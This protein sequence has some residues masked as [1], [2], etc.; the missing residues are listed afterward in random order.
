MQ[1]HTCALMHFYELQCL[2]KIFP[3]SN[4]DIRLL[5]IFG[6]NDIGGEGKDYMTDEGVG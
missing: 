6:D 5:V 3:I 4:P 2:E 1:L